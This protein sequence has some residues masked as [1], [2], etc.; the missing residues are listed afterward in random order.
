DGAANDD[1]TTDEEVLEVTVTREELA[2]LQLRIVHEGVALDPKQEWDDGQGKAG[3]FENRSC[4]VVLRGF[5][6]RNSDFLFDPAGPE[7][8][9]PLEHEDEKSPD[10][11]QLR[12]RRKNLLLR[13]VYDTEFQNSLV[14]NPSGLRVGDEILG[15]RR[16]SAAVTDGESENEKIAGTSGVQ[17]PSV[18]W[19]TVAADFRNLDFLGMGPSCMFLKQNTNK[20]GEN[21]PRRSSEP[22][23]EERP[24]FLSDGQ[25]G[26]DE[27]VE[28]SWSTSATKACFLNTY[29]V[30]RML[31]LC[32]D[33]RVSGITNL[34]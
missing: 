1:T 2:T 11:H 21:R 23:R 25:T 15:Y 26:S 30:K 29:F 7:T 14:D 28:F 33:E 32:D 9:D 4:V 22:E 8:L 31:S 3:C 20:S 24:L 13:A 12:L 16:L 27:D 19:H 34:P 5:N 10:P 6:I 18:E 17:K